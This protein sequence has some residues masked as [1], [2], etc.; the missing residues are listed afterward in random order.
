[1]KYFKYQKHCIFEAMR[2]PKLSSFNN[3]LHFIILLLS[4]VSV[5]QD[6]T[7][8]FKS[9]TTRNGLSSNEVHC[10]IQDEKGYMLFGTDRG[11][12][13]F[14]GINFATIPFE[15]PGLNDAVIFGFKKDLN[16]TIWLRTYKNGL[17]YLKNDTVKSYTFNQTLLDISKTS[18]T[19]N[20]SFPKTPYLL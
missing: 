20:F 5:A 1:M 10:S 2:K 3:L 13:K 14:D 7:Y 6:Y 18:F 11:L 17:F 8:N 19:D 16:N 4:L 12:Q 15:D 9:Y